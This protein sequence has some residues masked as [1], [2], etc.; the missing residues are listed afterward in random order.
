MDLKRA[1]SDLQKELQGIGVNVRFTATGYGVEVEGAELA[2]RLIARE[3]LHK[4]R[5]QTSIHYP[6]RP[7]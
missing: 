5:I 3:E 4:R 2:D 7:R 6:P 1:L